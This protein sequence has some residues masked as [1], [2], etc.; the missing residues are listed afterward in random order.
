MQ[1]PYLINCVNYIEANPVRANLTENLTEYPWSS[2][3]LR[4]SENNGLIDPLKI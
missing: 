1:N 3:K 2:Y 4:L